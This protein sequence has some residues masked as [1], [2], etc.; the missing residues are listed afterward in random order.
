MIGA[1]LDEAL[2]EAMG[3]DGMEEFVI[4]IA[5]IGKKRE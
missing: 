2:N 4:Y 3:V 5:S 1:Y